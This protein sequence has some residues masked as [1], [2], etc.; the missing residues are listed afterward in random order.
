MGDWWQRFVDMLQ[1][2]AIPRQLLENDIAGLVRNPWF[3]IPI[4]LLL[5][6]MIYRKAWRNI[7]IIALLIGLWWFS[8]SEF[9]DGT[10][11]DGKPVLAK[12]GPVVGVFILAVALIA[13]L[14]F[15]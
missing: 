6:W 13:Y 1:A 3:M 8:G 4:C 12:L 9:M 14:L 11:V 10:I 5:L 2:T 15:L 7:A